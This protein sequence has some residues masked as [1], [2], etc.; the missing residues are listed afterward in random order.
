MFNSMSASNSKITTTTGK[1]NIKCVY[2]EQTKFFVYNKKTIYKYIGIVK[3]R[4]NTA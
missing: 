2:T 4:L 1:N 3:H